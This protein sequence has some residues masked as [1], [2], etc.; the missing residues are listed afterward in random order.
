[1]RRILFA[2]A[3]LFSSMAFAQQDYVPRY[4][5]FAGYSY[6][7]SPKLNLAERGF[8]ARSAS[9]A[10]RGNPILATT[11]FAREPSF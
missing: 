3:L 7:N 2:F 10:K 11:L 4:D 8:I 9:R 6:L 1:M 5:A